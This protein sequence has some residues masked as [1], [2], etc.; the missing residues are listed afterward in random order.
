[1]RKVDFHKVR[2]SDNL[3]EK[4]DCE[5]SIARD[6]ESVIIALDWPD[7]EH[8]GVSL[9]TAEAWKLWELL[10]EYISAVQDDM[11]KWLATLPAA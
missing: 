4:G 7:G 11:E 8:D 1:M 9:T 10:P 2:L 5:A 6:S 3:V